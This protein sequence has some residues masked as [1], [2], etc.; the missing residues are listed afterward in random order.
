MAAAGGWGLT[1]AGA[2]AGTLATRYDTSLVVIG[3]LTTVLAVP[4]AAMQLPAGHLVDRFGA[5]RTALVGLGVVVLSYVAAVVVPVLAVAFGARILAGAGSAVGFVVG[6]DLARRAGVGPV[7]LGVFGGAAIGSGGLAVGV[8]PAL[9]PLLGWSAAWVTCAATAAAAI[10]A[11][12]VGVDAPSARAA[13]PA[14][15]AA[16]PSVLG[17]G[18]LY[19]LAAVHGVTLGLGVVLGNWA[20]VI[21]HDRWGLPSG[22][23]SAIASLVLL[24][25]IVSRPLG[26]YLAERFPHQMRWVVALALAV[27][28]IDTVALAFPSTAAVAVAVVLTLGV[29]SGLPFAA[30]LASAQRWRPDRPAAAVGLLNAMANSLVVI[31]TPLLAAAIESGQSVLALSV[32]G[33]LWL[34]PVAA[35]PRSL[36]RTSSR[37]RSARPGPP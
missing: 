8:V 19:R 18:E 10:V 33:A 30:V 3:L 27:C 5:R 29:A 36:S 23:S 32:T 24:T 16:G 17:D 13:R 22:A 25:T 11:V 28:A 4:Y 26:G 7:G 35:L 6:A 15:L 20:A 2:G 34:V 37:R 14:R 1:A 21:L 12:A 9:E 31:G